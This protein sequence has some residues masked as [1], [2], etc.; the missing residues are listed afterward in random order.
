MPIDEASLN[1]LIVESQDLQSDAMGQVESTLPD[2]ADI[3]AD[4][5]DQPVDPAQIAEFVSGRRA[6]LRRLGFGAAGVAASVPMV[7]ALTTLLAQPAAADQ[8]LDIQMLQTASSL[9]RLAVNTYGAALKLPF[10]SG[11]NPVVLKFAQTTM[12]QHD[13]HRQA[14]QAQTT[15]LG[16]KVQDNPNPKYLPVVQAATPN[17]KT[18]ADV[19]K[20][21]ATLEQVARDTYLNDLAMFSDTKS[22]QI[23]ASVMGVETQHLATLRA[24]GALLAA[25]APSL[26]AIPVDASKLPAVAGSVSFS[27]GPIITP[28][29]A[30]PPSE[31]ALQ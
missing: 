4:R 15:A 23:M 28:T 9:E 14:F 21:A 26:I 22:K 10:I 1:E 29:L 18:P 3:R 7:G 5:G 27:D 6:L 11:G 20:L 17:L 25:N 16:G 2:L 19:V 24:V 12:M 30:S 8:P 13:A 31:G